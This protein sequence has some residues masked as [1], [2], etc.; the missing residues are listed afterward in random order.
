MNWTLASWAV[1]A[2]V[3]A[4]ECHDMHAFLVPSSSKRSNCVSVP[5][6]QDR[7]RPSYVIYF[8]LQRTIQWL[9]SHEPE[10]I[11]AADAV[12]WVSHCPEVAD[13]KDPQTARGPDIIR[14]FQIK[15][16]KSGT[17]ERLVF[18]SLHTMRNTW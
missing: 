4:S 3:R 14:L 5:S 15:R 12:S 7:T 16:C 13:H 9:M 11:S 1:R 2:S 10:P 17:L 8:T 18:C 6:P